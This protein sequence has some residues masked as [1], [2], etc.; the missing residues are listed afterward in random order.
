M[1]NRS[2]LIFTLLL[3][4]GDAVAVLAAYTVAYILR[5]KL[6]DVPTYRTVPANEFFLSL[7]LLLPFI[8]ILFSLIGT[9]RTTYQG[10]IATVGR[11]FFGAGGAMLFMIMIHFFMNRPLFP[12]KLVPIYGLI[13]SI[14]FLSLERGALYF[15]R[16]IR[17]RRLIGVTD[18]VLVGDNE[19]AL[20]LARK[21]RDDRSY[22]IQAIVGNSKAA[23]HKTWVGAMRN[24][25]PYLIIQI[26]TR[27]VPNVDRALLDFAEKNYIEFKFV[28]REISD[29]PE[30]IKPELFMGDIPMMGVQPTPL[31]GWGRVAKRFFDIII[32]CLVLIILSPILLIIGILN[33][34]I[35][36]NVFYKHTRLTRG[37]HKFLLYKF[38]TARNDLN[39]LTPE[40][41]F[42]KI[43]HPELIKKYRE[44]GDFLR[45][46]PRYGA[47]SRFLRKTSLDEL[48]QLLNVIRGDISLVG[49]RALVPEEL[50]K[51]DQK[52]TVLNVKSGV[53]GLAQITGRRDLAWERRR[54]LDVY[55]VQNWSFALDLQILFKTFLQVLTGRGAR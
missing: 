20:E 39:G 51:F 45:D 18:V 50:N 11:I 53:T 22:K 31:L 47:W 2:S 24:F 23:T 38:Q 6:S 54:K 40:E 16:Y 4:I 55:Y 21:I 5:V 34:I 41:A 29:L 26:A 43:G 7:L 3:V 35:V 14:I 44:N 28:P 30:Q 49:P 36:G 25:K 10:K 33:K 46:D 12:S 37:D 8:I 42:T 52:H 17:R 48:P 19:I 27:E 13:F 1:R 15:A 32:S 9:Y